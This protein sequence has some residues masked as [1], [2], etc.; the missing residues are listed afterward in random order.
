MLYY[1]VIFHIEYFEDHYLVDRMKFI[2]R[3]WMLLFMII[4][5]DIGEV[6]FKFIILFYLYFYFMII[7]LH[8]HSVYYLI[9]FEHY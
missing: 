4:M 9:S 6:Y 8:S 7:Y 5:L 1:F 3:I 2:D